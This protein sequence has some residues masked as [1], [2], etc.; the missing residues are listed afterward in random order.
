MSRLSSRFA[1][2]KTRNQK[3]LIPYIVAG[4]PDASMTLNFMHTLV[5]AG[6]SVIELGMPFSDPMADGSTIQAGHERALKNKV[7]CKTIFSLV[8]EFRDSD[9]HTPVVLMGYLNPVEIFGYAAFADAAAKAGVDALLIVDLPP[10]EADELKS[11]LQ[12]QNMD[13]IFL[14][15]PTT[16]LE[17]T[18]FI[19]S[20]ASGFLYYVSLKGVTGA[21]NLDLNEVNQHL[22]TIKKLT[23]LPVNVGF[24]IKDGKSAAQL[25]HFADGVVVGSKLVEQCALVNSDNESTQQQISDALHHILADIRKAMDEQ[26]N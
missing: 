18:K 8:K 16:T 11:A 5:T 20:R 15:A 17:R 1:E 26:S 7:S 12:E 14:L 19:I 6:A 13:L 24:G 9:N 25:S 4:D 2:L 21:G 3:A 22:S 23:D 10:E